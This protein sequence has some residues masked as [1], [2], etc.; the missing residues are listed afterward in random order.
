[1]VWA[2]HCAFFLFFGKLYLEHKYREMERE[3]ETIGGR[4]RTKEHMPL[5]NFFD[6]IA[7]GNEHYSAPPPTMPKLNI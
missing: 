3:S 2:F 5:W 4:K 6:F 1:M 7:S